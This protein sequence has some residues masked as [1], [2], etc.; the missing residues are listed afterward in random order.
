MRGYRLSDLATQFG[1]KL[2]GDPDFH[3]TGVCTLLPGRAD[4]LSFVAGDRYRKHLADSQAGALVV[5]AGDADAWQ[6]NALISDNPH[7]DFAAIAALFDW[8]DQPTVSGIH[9]AAT[10]DESAQVHPS[11]CISAGVI[12]GAG[13]RIGADCQIGPGCVIGRNVELDEGARLIANVT[14]CDGVQLGKRVRLQ[15]GVVIGARGFGLAMTD[16]GWAEVPQLGSVRIG[17]DVEIGANSCVDRGAIDDTVIAN[18]VKIDNLV[19]VG[20]N[21]IIGEHTAIAGC[22]GIAGSCTIG[23]RCQI[24]GAAGILGHLSIADDVVIAAKSLVTSTISEPGL[25]SA[26]L[27]VQ[28]AAIWRRQLARLRKLDDLV[29]RIRALER[30][31]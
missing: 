1:L 16:N 29:G 22:V 27:P 23:A 20:H 26:S 18:G 28:P 31:R 14:L 10:V 15:P 24:G 5:G 12:I 30:D 6:G 13:A 8:R 11:A 4:A 21:S 2:K 9:S 25:Y 3:L 17:D 7:A 19:Q